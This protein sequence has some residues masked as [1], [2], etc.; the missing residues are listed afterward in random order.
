MDAHNGWS[1]SV[2][3][4][5]NASLHAHND[6]KFIML[7]PGKIAE[8]MARID[9]SMYQEYVTYSNNGV[10]MLYVRLSKALYGMLRAALLF[11][12]HKGSDLE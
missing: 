8:M 7:I 1:V 2:L 11:Y 10:H 12:K 5:A 9:P 3:D 4:A 6:E